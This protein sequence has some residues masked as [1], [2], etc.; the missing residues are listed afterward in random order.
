MLVKE[1]KIRFH[2]TKRFMAP[3][4]SYYQISRTKSIWDQLCIITKNVLWEF[5]SWNASGNMTC[6]GLCIEFQVLKLIG[7]KGYLLNFLLY[8]VSKL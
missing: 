4:Y 1:N 6:S 2:T 3:I 8:S 7:L 5:S